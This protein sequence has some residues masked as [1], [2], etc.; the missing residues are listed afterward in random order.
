MQFFITI[1]ASEGSQLN[2]FDDPDKMTDKEKEKYKSL[3]RTITNAN[4][5]ALQ[6]AKENLQ[7]SS[8]DML[9]QGASTL[10]SITSNLV[11]SGPMSKT[12]DMEGRAAAT[13][14]IKKMSEGFKT[15][16]VA[17]PNKLKSFIEATTGSAM[18]VMAGLNQILY[19][20]DPDEI[21]LTDFER[22]AS[23]PYDT[24]IPEGEDPDIPEDPEEALKKN[25][26]KLTRIRAIQQV[27]EMTALVDEIAET[28]IMNSVVG[29]VLATKS[30][31]GV[32]MTMAK[33][34]GSDTVGRDLDFDGIP[35]IPMRYTF[36]QSRSVVEFPLGFCPSTPGFVRDPKTLRK[37]DFNEDDPDNTGPCL[38]QW[39]FAFKEWE[40][41]TA[42]YPKTSNRLNFVTKQMDIDIYGDL[43]GKMEVKDIAG[44]ISITLERMRKKDPKLV[45]MPGAVDGDKEICDE[46]ELDKEKPCTQLVNVTDRLYILNGR[47][48]PPIIYHQVNVTRPHSTINVQIQIQ[49]PLESDMVIM[50]RRDKM[51]MV[52]KC[53]YVKIVSQIDGIDED[54]LGNANSNYV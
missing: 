5:E 25:A 51:P 23:M 28:T 45:S 34:K 40:A 53:D 39:G 31:L 18:A 33:L 30:P 46:K 49:N 43:G 44:N 32:Q 26:L 35:D 4:T 16:N 7:F 14:L 15:I 2:A 20:N 8:I 1:P 22:A 47:E 37:E 3:M 38:G 21:P 54:Y 24:D 29:E 10:Y 36:Q 17:D 19:S 52:E 9:E 11:G 12:L 6:S 48:K 50:A 13:E 42:T 27:K 41:I